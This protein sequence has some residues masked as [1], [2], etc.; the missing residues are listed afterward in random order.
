MY[1]V[2]YPWLDV[3][4]WP[5]AP[6][7]HWS[8]CMLSNTSWPKD[9]LICSNQNI[10]TKEFS[11]ILIGRPWI[12]LEWRHA[13]PISV[14]NKVTRQSS[15]K[16]GIVLRIEPIAFHQKIHIGSDYQTALSEFGLKK[17]LENIYIPK[18][19][20]FPKNFGIFFVI[21]KKECLWKNNRQW[22]CEE[23]FKSLCWKSTEFIFTSIV[24]K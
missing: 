5:M 22:I 1:A 11:N 16:V 2:G 8:G 9:V 19:Q 13:L 15:S 23:N 24:T 20:F 4:Q 3:W 6:C 17:M 21:F 14:K 7:I 12:T 18:H 10:G